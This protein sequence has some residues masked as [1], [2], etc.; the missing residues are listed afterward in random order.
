MIDSKT[1][2]MLGGGG[3]EPQEPG[4][5]EPG[6]REPEWDLAVGEGDLWWQEAEPHPKC[7]CLCEGGGAGEERDGR[8]VVLFC[9]WSLPQR[10]PDGV[11]LWVGGGVGYSALPVFTPQIKHH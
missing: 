7:T 10:T 4:P 1:T 6:P 11:R 3:P 5:R 9:Y 8:G 2:E